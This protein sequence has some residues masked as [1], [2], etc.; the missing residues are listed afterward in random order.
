MQSLTD[1]LSP[2]TLAKIDNYHLLA[3]IVVDGYVA[4]M[5]RSLYHGFG[6][7]FLQYRNYSPGDDLRYVDWKVYGRLD[8][9]HTKVYQEETNFSCSII[10]DASASMDYQGT[11]AA[12]G[13]FRYA[14]MI[15]ACLA[16]L[17]FRQGDDVGLFVYNDKLVARVPPSRRPGHLRRIISEISRVKPENVGHHEKYLRYASEALRRRGLVFIISDFLD[18][19][20]DVPG[21]LR[22]LRFPRHDCVALQTLDADELDLP[23]EQTIRFLDSESGESIVTAP[24]HV[25][26]SYQNA[27]RDYLETLR[28]T[29]FDLQIDYLR[30]DTTRDLGAALAA[31]L[32]HRGA[33]YG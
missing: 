26:E 22:K 29:C 9:L 5:H 1:M 19:E 6:S 23:F 15:A 2:T 33:V 18:L 12:C 20:A 17:A 16:Y 30:M 24:R 28:K 10:L 7:E 32:H 11:R 4:G 14:A 3:R 25:R 27:V 21:L 13:K 31:Y 8:R